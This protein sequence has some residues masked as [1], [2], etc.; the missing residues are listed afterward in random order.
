MPVSWKGLKVQLEHT[1]TIIILALPANILLLF[2]K[3]WEGRWLVKRI[4]GVVW[5]LGDTVKKENRLIIWYL[6][7]KQLSLLEAHTPLRGFLPYQAKRNTGSLSGK[8]LK[9][10]KKEK[11]VFFLRKKVNCKKASKVWMVV[12]VSGVPLQYI[13]HLKKWK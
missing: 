6:K 2:Q 11:K 13:F 10:F 3:R 7:I 8:N 1:S 12:Y 9:P 5:F 4:V